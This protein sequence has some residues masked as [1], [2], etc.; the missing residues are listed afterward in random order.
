MPRVLLAGPYAQGVTKVE[1]PVS[2]CEPLAHQVKRCLHQAKWLQPG[3]GR[4]ER[5]KS[6]S[7]YCKNGEGDHYWCF[8]PRSNLLSILL[9]PTTC[10]HLWQQGAHSAALLLRHQM[11]HQARSEHH[12]Q[13]GFWPLCS[14]FSN[15]LSPKDEVV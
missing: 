5:R 7:S 8:A 3:Q 10:Y 15:W 9:L 4:T 13:W 11:G 1:T 12:G 14:G 2:Y 6:Y